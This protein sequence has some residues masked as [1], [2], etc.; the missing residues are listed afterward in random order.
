M[1]SVRQ[2]FRGSDLS[3]SV[4]PGEVLKRLRQERGWTLS[5]V[6]DMTGL[7]I[8]TLSKVEN[9]KM[10]LSY[11]KLARISKG[12]DI[13]IG[14]LFSKG[15]PA[16]AEP[17]Q[18][19]GRR[20]I[21]RKGEAASIETKVYSHLYPASDLLNKRFVPILAEL[22]ARTLEE[23]GEMIRH[24]GEEYA[25]VVEGVAELHTDLYAPVR[26]ERGDSIYFDSGMAHAYL[27]ASDEPC[28]VLSICSG[29]ETQVKAAVTKP[30]NDPIAAPSPAPQVKRARKVR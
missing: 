7:P 17:E 10:S 27:K 16:A 29:E 21:T 19:T 28:R 22:H 14:A 9:D 5:T 25:Y 6:S 24:P 30:A 23:F 8:S 12:L 1:L 2:R 4:K 26:L 11:D 18:V 15:E 13:D 3:G 20:S